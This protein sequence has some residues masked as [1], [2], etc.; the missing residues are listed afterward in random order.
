MKWNFQKVEEIQ[1]LETLCPFQ[2][3]WQNVQ[4]ATGA[5]THSLLWIEVMPKG[6]DV[7]V[8]NTRV[9]KESI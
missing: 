2:K 9:C 3:L 8:I 4:F 5:D 7:G 6:T 1:T